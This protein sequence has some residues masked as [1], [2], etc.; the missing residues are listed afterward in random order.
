MSAIDGEAGLLPSVMV[1]GVHAVATPARVKAAAPVGSAYTFTAPF[2]YSHKGIHVA[3]RRGHTV[4][5]A[6]DLKA[7][8]LAAV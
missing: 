3:F 4:A 7:V 5:L 2:A 6:A 8:L 1:N